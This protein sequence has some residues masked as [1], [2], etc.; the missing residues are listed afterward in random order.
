MYTFSVEEPLSS[1][2]VLGPYIAASNQAGILA[3][4]DL[5]YSKRYEGCHKDGHENR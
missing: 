5:I 2:H 4:D 3:A 1:E